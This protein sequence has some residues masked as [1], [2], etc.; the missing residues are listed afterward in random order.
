MFSKTASQRA[1]IFGFHLEGKTN[2]EPY[3]YREIGGRLL[4]VETRLANDLL[5][6][7]GDFSLEGLRLWKT[8]FLAMAQSPRPGSPLRNSQSAADKKQR[9]SHKTSEEKKIVIM[10]CK[11]APTSQQVE[12]WLQAKEDYEL[13]RKRIVIKG[14]EIATATDSL[15]CI[16]LP[17]NLCCEMAKAPECSD[18][19]RAEAS[20]SP[21]RSEAF[22][23]SSDPTAPQTEGNCDANNIELSK[24]AL[25][26]RPLPLVTTAGETE[27]NEEE[28][29]VNCSSPDSPVPPWQQVATPDSKQSCSEDSEG[30]VLSAEESKTV[31]RRVQKLVREEGKAPLSVSPSRECDGSS[32]NIC[33]HSTPIREKMCQEGTA[34]AFAF[35][36]VLP[37][38]L[39]K[40]SA[41]HKLKIKTGEKINF[42]IWTGTC[43]I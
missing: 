10:P 8:A 36:P 40:M 20:K 16:S 33:F 5:E 15:K 41:V 6:F 38:T 23:V 42:K 28:D 1:V 43:S 9:N 11:C 2:S 7:E 18:L 29:Y 34:E 13:F 39:K 26:N 14:T 19:P 17:E 21:V 4:T 35:T 30:L 24:T 32:E 37:G 25:K 27:K 12:S 3:L 22:C 31:A